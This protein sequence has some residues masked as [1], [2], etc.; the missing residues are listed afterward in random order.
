MGIGEAISN[1]E[2]ISLNISA[3]KVL[4]WPHL[5]THLAR[6]LELRST[7]DGSKR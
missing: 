7:D 5:Y 1:L 4:R 3:P 6:N 2:G